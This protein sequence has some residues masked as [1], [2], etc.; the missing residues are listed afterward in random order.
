MAATMEYL[1]CM[2]EYNVADTKFLFTTVSP[3]GP[4]HKDT[5]ATWVKNTLTQ[6]A[7]N[8][9]FFSS[10]S[11]RSS[12]SSKADNMGM[13]LDTILKMGCWC[14]QSTLRKFYSKELQYMDKDNRI[15]ETIAKSLDN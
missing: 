9:N 2:A 6:A 8:T 13:D 10:H 1:K 5:I 7:V 14:Q 3:Y 12:A 11:C 15:T 4:S